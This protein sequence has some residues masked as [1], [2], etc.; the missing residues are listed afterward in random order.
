MKSYQD[1]TGK[2]HRTQA[3]AK[4]SGRP[5]ELV[6]IPTD[7]AGLITFI[8]DI[9]GRIVSVDH[10]EVVAHFDQPSELFD[11]PAYQN[12]HPTSTFMKSR[13][14]AAVFVCTNCGHSNRNQAQ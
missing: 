10:E 13:D 8:N 6:D 1:D 9:G 5:F 3:D 2:F 11:G 12:G 14:P 4:A 7:H